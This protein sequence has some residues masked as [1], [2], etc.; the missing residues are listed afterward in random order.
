ML[1][2]SFSVGFLHLLTLRLEAFTCFLRWFSLG[3][4]HGTYLFVG[5]NGG[6]QLGFIS[7]SFPQIDWTTFSNGGMVVVSL[8]ASIHFCFYLKI[9]VS[10]MSHLP[11]LVVNFL[12]GLMFWH[13][14]VTAVFGGEMANAI[15]LWSD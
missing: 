11:A 6:K 8:I 13:V 1:Y 3:V 10:K 12:V 14:I 15:R 5:A 7:S 2:M 9:F 4:H